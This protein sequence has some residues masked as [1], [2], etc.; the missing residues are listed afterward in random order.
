MTGGP[1]FDEY[2]V[3]YGLQS[4]NA[5]IPNALLPVPYNVGN[6][7]EQL[8]LATSPYA[9]LGRVI[10]VDVIKAFLT[11]HKVKYYEDDIYDIKANQ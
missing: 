1:V 4:Q 3:I 5:V 7:E 8:K 2:G 10:N 9:L 6:G 11:E